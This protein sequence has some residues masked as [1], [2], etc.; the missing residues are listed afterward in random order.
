LI[1][2]GSAHWVHLDEPEIV[3]G[4]IREMVSNDSYD[5]RQRLAPES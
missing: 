4:A 5:K 1:A 3:I 2:S